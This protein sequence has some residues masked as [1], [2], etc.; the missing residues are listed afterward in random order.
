MTLKSSF[1]LM[2]HDDSVMLLSELQLLSQRVQASVDERKI[3][4]DKLIELLSHEHREALDC[5]QDREKDL[6]AVLEIAQEFIKKAGKS[7]GEIEKLKAELDKY[8][9]SECELKDE[10]E[11]LKHTLCTVNEG[12]MK[13]SNALMESERT[14]ARLE[15]QQ[16]EVKMPI[17]PLSPPL[18]EQDSPVKIDNSDLKAKSLAHE[19]DRLKRKLSAFRKSLKD[20]ENFKL[21]AEDKAK[22]MENTVKNLRQQV[23]DL[24]SQVE[25]FKQE[26]ETQAARA[27][28]SELKTSTLIEKLSGLEEEL[29]LPSAPKPKRR[30]RSTAKHLNFC[31]LDLELL[32]I[33][34]IHE[35]SKENQADISLDEYVFSGSMTPSH[36]KT[37]VYYTPDLSRARTLGELS[38]NSIKVAEI[39]ARKRSTTRKSASEEFFYLTAQSVKMNSS[40]MDSICTISTRDLFLQAQKESIPFHKWHSWLERMFEKY[41]LR[42][43]RTRQGGR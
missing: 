13:V 31:S 5:L 12:Y 8:H 25:S 23:A 17:T 35:A 14:I 18:V 2:L 37:S 27:N 22:S 43:Q 1:K 4:E 26:A 19:V 39:R 33:E 16:V 9:K 28:D 42:S 7:A 15:M 11:G 30:T 24:T 36:S 32:E 6:L 41:Y 29:N 21:Q 34:E 3:A 10:V 40:H 38:T 20:T